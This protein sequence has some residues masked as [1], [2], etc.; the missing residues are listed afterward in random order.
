MNCHINFLVNS[1]QNRFSKTQ[2]ITTAT[3]VLK[4]NWSAKLELA[5]SNIEIVAMI[6][7]HHDNQVSVEYVADEF[8]FHPVGSH[9]PVAPPMPPHVR[10]ADYMSFMIFFFFARI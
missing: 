10:W 6:I 3:P 5:A 7:N 1:F 2:F 4:A 9:I 8:G